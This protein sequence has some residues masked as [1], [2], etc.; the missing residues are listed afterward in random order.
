MAWFYPINP[1]EEDK[2]W[3]QFFREAAV[4]F[5][6]GTYSNEYEGQ[7]ITEFK[8]LLPALPVKS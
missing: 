3:E 6:E 2:S 8:K 7:L 5:R 1:G 4:R